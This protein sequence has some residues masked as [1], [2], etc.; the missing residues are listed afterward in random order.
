MAAEP[1]VRVVVMRDGGAVPAYQLPPMPPSGPD[2]LLPAGLF[3]MNWAGAAAS[4]KGQGGQGGQRDN[5]AEGWGGQTCR[6]IGRGG[7]D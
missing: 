6:S 3:Q 7:K 4:G 5:S 1:N 2:Q